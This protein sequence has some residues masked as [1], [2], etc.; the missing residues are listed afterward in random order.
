MNQPE[1][2]AHI[3]INLGSID[4]FPLVTLGGE[5][6]AFTAPFTHGAVGALIDAGYTGIIIDITDLRY[7]DGAGFEALDSCCTK[8]KTVDGMLLIVNP[9]ANIEN[10][11]ELLREKDSCEIECDVE[12]AL[13]RL[14]NTQ[15]RK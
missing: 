12:S 5:C 14:R 9:G 11:Y 4:G 1:K 15:G 10:I 2:R 8:I 13:A 3:Q 7:M 6:D